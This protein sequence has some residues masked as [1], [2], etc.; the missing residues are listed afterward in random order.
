[1]KK[2]FITGMGGQDGILL[3]RVFIRSWV[4]RFTELFEEIQHQS[5]NKA[6]LII[7]DSI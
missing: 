5:I 1:M 3:S 7:Q 6:V 4:M 2:A